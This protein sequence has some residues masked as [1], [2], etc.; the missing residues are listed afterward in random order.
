[1]RDKLNN[2]PK[3]QMAAVGALLLAAAFFV[4]STM[5]GGKSSASDTATTTDPAAAT[6]PVDPAT[7]APAAVDPTT[8]AP[9]APSAAIPI[10]PAPPLPKDV[11]AAYKRNETIALLVVKRGAIDDK[12]V[13]V[14]VSQLTAN[15]VANFIVPVSQIAKYTA[16]TQGVNVDRT[17]AL[18][19]VRPKHLTTGAPTATVSYSFQSREAV[20]Q[21]VRDATYTGPSTTYA[22]G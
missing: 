18:V 16:I 17:P 3:V 15:H 20:D 7:G 19:V 6:A 1:M 4:I 13:A 2:D 22:P 14:S 5:G 11:Q 12:L 8:G 9:A 10:V 21:A